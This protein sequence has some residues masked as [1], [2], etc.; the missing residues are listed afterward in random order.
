[1]FLLQYLVMQTGRV[2][3]TGSCCAVQISS[4]MSLP[5]IIPQV[6]PLHRLVNEYEWIAAEMLLVFM[7]TTQC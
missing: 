4:C 2:Q 1:M 6:D 7:Y 3:K 5:A